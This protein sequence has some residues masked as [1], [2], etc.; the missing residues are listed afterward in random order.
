MS[1][2]AT[3]KPPPRRSVP[4]V[5]DQLMSVPLFASLPPADV[6]ALLRDAKIEHC[7]DNT[8]LFRQGEAADRFYLV[9]AGY[10]E[11]FVET[12]DGRHGVVEIMRPGDVFAEAAI[13]DAG[14]FPVGARS[15]DHAAL[16]VVPAPSFL[17]YLESRF[18]LVLL[19]LGSMS[20]R[21]RQ[22]VH[23]ITEL[24][25][26]STAQRLGGFLLGM[27]TAQS[28][29]AVVRFPYDKKLVA[30][31][32]GMKPESLSR[33][34]AKLRKVGVVSEQDNVAS[35]ADVAK[36]RRFCLEDDTE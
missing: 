35:I 14:R 24:K 4:D 12:G 9:L 23:Q 18:D 15:F 33:A 8:I 36:L 1:T 20:L 10:V 6:E 2:T 27:T 21:L 32:L 30:E 19:M 25:L 29:K 11:L 7:V 13:F 28:G 16:L 5:F 26:K 22:L 31:K 17:G 3:M 34:L